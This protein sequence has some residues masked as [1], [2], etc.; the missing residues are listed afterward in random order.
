MQSTLGAEVDVRRIGLWGTSFAGG[1]VLVTAAKEGINISAVVSQV[2]PASAE[3]L[4]AVL[5]SRQADAVVSGTLME[6]SKC[7]VHCLQVPH[8]SG[9]E[10]SKRSLKNRGIPQSV[11]LFLAGLHDRARVLVGQSP[12]YL[13]VAGP[14]GSNSFME[15]PEEEMQLYL[16]KHPENYMVRC[17]A[18][19]RDCQEQSVIS[20]KAPE[21]VRVEL[22]Y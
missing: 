21:L 13:K 14:P 8:L 20:S 16:A 15:L 11:R 6:Q 3:L 5:L 10:A 4:H 7:F 18:V 2:R 12:A 17:A 19:L 22:C 1:H 9:F